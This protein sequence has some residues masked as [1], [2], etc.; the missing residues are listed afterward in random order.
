MNIWLINQYAN[1]PSLGTPG[2]HYFIAKELIKKNCNVSIISSSNN[3]LRKSE[4]NISFFFRKKV[5]DEVPFLFLRTFKYNKS[6]SF[7]RILNWLIFTFKILF[8]P[9][10]LKK[11]DF[12]IYSSPSPF[13]F[14][15]CFLLSK[16]LRCKLIFEVRDIW[17]LSLTQIGGLS[18]NN[19][20]IKFMNFTEYL[21]YKYSY[22]VWSNLKFSYK[23]MLTNG[24]DDLKNFS[25]HPNGID[26]IDMP[27]VPDLTNDQ[28]LNV[29]KLK[30]KSLL[31][32]YI[33]SLGDANAIENFLVSIK[34][35]N[36]KFNGNISFIIIGSGRSKK[37]L[38]KYAETNNLNNVFFFNSVPY[39]QVS[40]F[41]SLF[42]I[43]YLGTKDISIYKYGIASLK[44]PEYMYNSKPIIHS[45][46]N[47]IVTDAKCGFVVSP[48]DFNGLSE[49]FNLVEY[50]N[51][52][53][54]NK[55]GSN[56]YEFVR[57]NLSYKEISNNIY[58]EL[59]TYLV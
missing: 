45:A 51:A 3:H 38:I 20:L 29:K 7:K 36:E 39:N 21:S 49:V 46:V 16:I 14:Y 40:S 12:I 5:I 18:S 52:N 37:T 28:F 6:T 25:W 55:L 10:F 32:G 24:L 1:A 59:R 44:L 26:F 48:S 41:I 31:I 8:I 47:S 35:Y 57:N 56:G 34:L 42:D 22:K 23:H 54:L 11:P 30:E 58:K 17:P 15:S 9:F 50:L 4:V 19:I 27:E 2:R 13:G 53:E 33:G 43:C